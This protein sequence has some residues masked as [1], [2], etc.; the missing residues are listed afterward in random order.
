ML[1][2]KVIVFHRLKCFRKFLRV[3]KVFEHFKLSDGE[4]TNTIPTLASTQ[5][6]FSNFMNFFLTSI[7]CFVFSPLGIRRFRYLCNGQTRSNPILFFFMKKLLG[8]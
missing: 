1:N 7:K 5:N 8:R 4:G 3:D 6:L 2:G